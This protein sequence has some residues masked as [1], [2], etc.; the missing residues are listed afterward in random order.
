[1]RLARLDLVRYGKFTDATIDFGAAEPGR[2][3]LHLVYGPNEAGKSTTFAAWLDLLYGIETRTRY[4]FL[5]PYASM[6][7]GARLELDGQ[8]RELA[9]IKRPHNSL[10]DGDDQPVAEHAVLAALGGVDREAYRTMFS[11]DDHSLEAGGESILASRGE[12]GRMLFAATSGLADFS[13]ALAGL[14]EEAD[15]FYRYRAR[16]GRLAEMKA[17]LAE[18]KEQRRAID[19]QASDFS[20][21]VEERE[22]ARERYEQAASERAQAQARADAIRRLLQAAPRHAELRRL[23][24]VLAPLQ[25]LP[26][27]PEG[28]T[29]ELPRLQAERIELAARREAAAAAIAAL[30]V[31]IDAVAVDETALALGGRLEQL[32]ILHAR[33][34]SAEEDLPS[35]RQRLAET[36]AQIDR[37]AET[38]SARPE[39]AGLLPLAAA[40]TG[41]L[42]GL[43]ERRSGIEAALAAAREELAEAERRRDAA[44]REAEAAGGAERGPA[45]AI[46]LSAALGALRDSDHAARGRL[47][48][49]QRLAHADA[50]AERMAALRPWT[51]DLDALAAL[52]VPPAAGMEAWERRL[53]A[54]EL[55]LA[56]DAGQVERLAAE[57]RRLKGEL[58]ALDAAGGIVTDGEAAAARADRERAWA[59]HRR[60]LDPGTADAFEA[61]MRRDDLVTG[62]RLANASAVERANQ[63]AQALALASA[64]LAEARQARD[65]AEAA[66][67]G[68]GGE[69]AAAVARLSPLLPAD[70]GLLSLRDWLE[71]RRQA[72]DAGRLLRQTERALAEADADGRLLRER[73][74]AALADAGIVHDGDASLDRLA[75]VAQAALDR[76]AQRARLRALVQERESEAEARAVALA[77]AE[78][79]EADWNAAWAEACAGNWLG[80]RRPLPDVAAVGE[81]LP[82]L[83]ALEPLLRERDQLADRIAKMTHDQTVFA[84]EAGAM[85]EALGLDRAGPALAVFRAVEAVIARARTDAERLADRRQRLDE[86]LRGRAVLDEKLAVNDG[87]GAR[88]TAYFSVATFDE[89]AESLRQAGRRDE[90]SARARAFEAELVETVRADSLAEAEALVAGADRDA[91]DR[92]LAELEPRLEALDQHL[93]ELFSAHARSAERVEAV[94]GDDAVAMIEQA[95]RTVL[96]EIEDRATAWFRLRAGALAAEAALRTYRDRH[97]SAVMRRASEAFATISRGAYGGLAAQP[98]RDGEVLVAKAA[99]G[100]S[101]LAADLSRGT[102]FQLYLALR[103]AGYLD[104]AANR[105]PVPFVADDIMETFDDFRAEEA[106]RLFATMAEAG[107][108]IYLTHHRHLIDIARRVCPDVRVHEL[109]G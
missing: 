102:R 54:A 29:D 66:L 93:R 46:A 4:A 74:A 13:H 105:R 44:R 70:L 92:E 98:D 64:T 10:L 38:L 88:M 15:G 67:A 42:R 107:Q 9:R 52:D 109:P 19:T 81:I 12:L 22:A 18:L 16:T 35:R 65:R 96:A 40:T 57:E 37:L 100:T 56:R 84:A 61:L 75:A 48:G 77:R 39:E 21:L 27:A 8:M 51:G 49:R 6:R 104:F 91:L 58:E 69:I 7:V 28:W 36:Q 41:T 76:E 11:L 55:A 97:R 25:G 82:R 60:A 17:R 26:A 95:R 72:L 34:V 1:M 90:L 24:E 87:L 43:M 78:A 85:A 45:A 30:E 73:L 32:G 103:V 59:E 79:A 108:V 101:K 80:A 33:H 89:V 50:L 63:T 83:A 3:D 86:A 68:L 53:D 99:D 5:H 94:G 62:A 2:P 71:R 23:R 106:F 47:A 31:E 14:T 20:R